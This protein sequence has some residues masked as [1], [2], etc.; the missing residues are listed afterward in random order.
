MSNITS[1]DEGNIVVKANGKRLQLS[2]NK[3]SAQFVIDHYY[4]FS[5]HINYNQEKDIEIVVIDLKV[6]PP[7]K[8]ASRP[9]QVVAQK[10]NKS[11][12]F[13]LERNRIKENRFFGL[14]MPNDKGNLLMTEVISKLEGNLLLDERGNRQQIF[15]SRADGLF[16]INSFYEFSIHVI[17]NNGDNS[18][19][20]VVDH[21]N[22]PP[23]EIK[24]DPFKE[25]VRLRYE[26]LDNPEANR[27][28]AHLMREIGRGLY[29][30]KQRMIFELLQ[31]ADDTPAGDEVSFHID[32]HEDYMLFMHNGI[33]FNRDDVEAITSAAESTKRHDRKKTGYKGIGFKSVFTDSEEVIIKSG[34]FLFAFK[35][36]YEG[37]EKFDDFYFSKQRYKEHEEI[38]AEDKL[39]FNRQRLTF[40]GKT[41]I[42]WQLIPIWIESVPEVLNSSRFVKYNN[43]VGIAIKFGYNRVQEYLKAVEAFASKP[44]FM[45]FL[46]NV[47]LF[48]SFKNA[49]TIRKNGINPVLIQKTSGDGV[50]IQLG[51]LKKEI[52]EIEVND[53]SLHDE[54][55]LIYKKERVNEYGEISYYFSADAE[56]KIEIESIPPKLAAFDKTTITLA[57]PIVDNKLTAEPDYLRN[58]DISSFFTYLPMK[59]KRIRL[60]FLVNADF[61]PSSDRESLQ[62]DN[63][64]NEY[65]ISKIARS[66]VSWLNELAE[67]AIDNSEVY[68]EYLSLLLS[69]LLPDEDTIQKLIDRYNE[70]YYKTLIETPFVL[71]DGNLI[72][73]L[74][75][76]LIDISNISVYIGSEDFYILTKTSKRLPHQSLNSAY[77]LSDYLK[78]EA[79]TFGDFV[80]IIAESD[81]KETFRQMIGKLNT[82]SYVS[83]LSW[84]NDQVRIYDVEKVWLKTLPFL[85]IDSNILSFEE[86]LIT[87]DLLLKH[88]KINV[89]EAIL[90]KLGFKLT[91]HSID[92]YSDLWDKLDVF[93]I[94]DK[95]LYDRISK[96]Q[97]L[98]QLEFDEKSI[99][100]RFLEGLDRV[101]KSKFAGE[102]SLFK[103]QAEGS[104]L[105]PLTKLISNSII[106]IPT[107]L[108]SLRIDLKEEESLEQN[109]RKYLIDQDEILVK[110]FNDKELFLEVVR[111]INA[112]NVAQF[113]SY[114]LDLLKN[115][116]TELVGISEIPWLFIEG[117]NTF[118]KA[119]EAYFPESLTNLTESKYRN[120]KLAIEGLSSLNIPHY[121]SLALIKSLSLGYKRDRFIEVIS[122]PHIVKHEIANDFLDWLAQNKESNFFE[123]FYFLKSGNDYELIRSQGIIQFYSP[124][125]EFVE[126]IRKQDKASKFVLLDKDLYDTTRKEIGL[127]EGDLLIEKLIDSNIFDEGLVQFLNSKTSDTTVIKFLFSLDS[128]NVLTQNEYYEAS[129]EYKIIK[130]ASD[131]LTEDEAV[132]TKFRALLNVDN[133]PLMDRA[134]SDDIYFHQARIEL[135][136][137]LSEIL[138]NYKNQTYSLSTVMNAFPDIDKTK[139]RKL[140]EP[141]RILPIRIFEELNALT[142]ESFNPAQTFFLLFYKKQANLGSV[143]QQK[144]NFVRYYENDKALYSKSAAEFLDIC[145]RQDYYIGFADHFQLP[146][147]KCSDL[148]IE[149]SYALESE[150]PPDWVK[151]WLTGE[152]KTDKLKLLKLLGVNDLESPVVQ[153]RKAIFDG[154]ADMD[155]ARGSLNNVVLFKNTLEWLRQ[156]T[157]RGEVK[158]NEDLLKSLYVKVEQL[159]IPVKE[160][161]IPVLKSIKEL[162]YA[163]EVFNS[164]IEYHLFHEGWGDYKYEV[165]NYLNQN[166]AYIISS[167]LPSDYIKQLGAKK[168]SVIEELDQVAL[169][170]KLTDFKHRYYQTWPK[171]NLFPIKVYKGSE[172]P[173]QIVYDTHNIKSIVKNTY[174]QVKDYL[175][176]SEDIVDSIPKI[177]KGSMPH[178]LYVDLNSYKTDFEDNSFAINYTQEEIEALNRLYQDGIPDVFM[179]DLNLAALV[180]ALVH[181]PEDG[182]DIN[183]ASIKLEDTHTFAQ[184]FPVV[185]NS[186]VYTVMGRSARQGLLYMTAKAW[187]RLDDSSVILYADLGN[188]SHRL[189]YNKQNVLDA[190]DKSTDYQILRIETEADASNIDAILTGN[191]FQRD[192]IWMI[193]RIKENK[194]YDSLFYKKFEPDSTYENS[195]TARTDDTGI[196]Y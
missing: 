38:L 46:R 15:L 75:N 181:L 194:N 50:D 118:V 6:K 96:S 24:Y 155:V 130:L 64:W 131:L 177:I 86:I 54:G 147:L 167:I 49:I 169:Q 76:I 173:Y 190:N 19:I 102:L 83:F 126:Y 185:K 41:D 79:F 5:I 11:V 139:L 81:R 184:L 73:K 188:D 14:C 172:L 103:S 21:K 72:L 159:K 153:L 138:P 66:H 26:R 119:D 68:Q 8:L 84:L 89:V 116:K 42:P 191:Y 163:L 151:D 45:L 69:D 109:F 143:F 128:I 112:E 125:N 175:V 162:G 160:I 25:I 34:G 13:F 63:Q 71:A 193:F 117:K 158:L 136:I 133:Y 17:I 59:E 85:S 3:D 29:S 101:G 90:I 20:V 22:N 183:E 186:A 30:S 134:I 61:V 196:S 9:A 165:F 28:I 88:S 120:V 148:I 135:K 7:I 129:N 144:G 124:S 146:D 27:M 166:K 2:L 12:A 33:P 55:I 104:V 52:D 114:V 170:S 150:L 74:E 36:N 31:N 154:V 174:A 47:T 44:H 40:Q 58:R 141:Q 105:K 107:W 178:D 53:R 171:K 110:V 164:Q 1:K 149:S 106:N 32:A 152:D 57:A 91:T 140:F 182:F 37:F 56:G 122:L 192:K 113:Y 187:D 92:T 10:I 39:K 157:L 123:Q 161:A 111:N 77:L 78:V 180:S 100:I 121:S 82:E 4:E 95:D 98:A 65:I 87:D 115:K 176:V 137:K 145:I 142:I 99:L 18:E 62:G 189:F 23:L 70:V 80:K 35:R 67:S 51:Y 43:N 179:K 97:N 60:P 16:K 108:E 93:N 132:A 127:V 156:K 168:L 48:K 94:S 195:A